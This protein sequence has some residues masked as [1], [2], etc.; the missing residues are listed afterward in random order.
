[1][2]IEREKVRENIRRKQHKEHIGRYITIIIF[3]FNTDVK[4]A[5]LKQGLFLT[6]QEIILGGQKT[7]V[8]II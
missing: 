7:I 1:M 4:L 6:C 5:K 8:F 3:L 2:D